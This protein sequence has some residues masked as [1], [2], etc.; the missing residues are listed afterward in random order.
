MDLGYDLDAA[1]RLE[2]KKELQGAVKERIGG[3]KRVLP[4]L[5]GFLIF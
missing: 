5:S 1:G 3:L 4:K 2:A